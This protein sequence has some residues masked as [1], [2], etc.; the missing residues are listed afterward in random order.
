M[1]E[2][3]L[4]DDDFYL[5]LPVFV[6]FDLFSTMGHDRSYDGLIIEDDVY[7]FRPSDDCSDPDPDDMVPE[8]LD[9]FVTIAIYPSDNLDPELAGLKT[10]DGTEWEKY[11]AS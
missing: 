11:E 6:Q 7:Y 9:G 8:A 1:A 4:T 3:D 5:S 10:I 2:L